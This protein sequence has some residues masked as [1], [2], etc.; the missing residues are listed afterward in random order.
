MESFFLFMS[1]LSKNKKCA[2][3]LLKK[4]ITEF[5]K[6]KQTKDGL[7]PYCKECRKVEKL[8]YRA[9]NLEKIKQQSRIYSGK[10]K[11][12]ISEMA[13]ERRLKNL[14]GYREK[15]R[16]YY[17][18]NKEK[19]KLRKLRERLLDPEK[20]KARYRKYYAENPQRQKERQKKYDSKNTE[21]VKEARAKYRR[22]N[23]EKR[24]EYN[25][26]YNELHR[27]ER[28]I[29]A[30]KYNQINSEKV[31]ARRSA[32]KMANKEKLLE[33]GRLWRKKNPE[34]A[35]AIKLRRRD[36]ERNCESHISSEDIKKLRLLQKNKCP[37]CKQEFND[38]TIKI[39]VDHIIPLSVIE[40]RKL[41]IHDFMLLCKSCNSKKGTKT[42]AEFLTTG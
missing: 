1:E 17:A 16:Q 8:E 22:L 41:G 5:H 31:K 11:Q 37:K 35:A 18:E 6:S 27:I 21:K 12:R 28:S 34:K 9:K 13:K 42:L 33:A 20:Y 2:K 40:N 38:T 15:S 36:R 25:I 26:K 30:K 32:Y 39:S 19:E 23:A 24:K 4:G 10:N 3:C 29:Y 7:K 14:E